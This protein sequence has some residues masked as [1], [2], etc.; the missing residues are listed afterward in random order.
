MFG[1]NSN[2]HSQLAMSKR[3]MIAN[4]VTM[5]AIVRLWQRGGTRRDFR[6][7][8]GSLQRQKGQQEKTMLMLLA[9]TIYEQSHITYRPPSPSSSVSH[10]LSVQTKWSSLRVKRKKK[11]EALLLHLRDYLTQARCPCMRK[12]SRIDN[13]CANLGIA[14]QLNNPDAFSTQRFSI[15]KWTL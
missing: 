12:Q 11:T 1:W 13:R 7:F 3:P 5:R 9:Y 6:L 2:I 10:F 8:N 4:L 14:F 15:C